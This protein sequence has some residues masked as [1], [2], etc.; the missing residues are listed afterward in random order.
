M[1]LNTYAL[2]QVKYEGKYYKIWFQITSTLQKIIHLFMDQ[3]IELKYGCNISPTN[4]D[5][6]PLKICLHESSLLK[7]GSGFFSFDMTTSL[8][9]E[10]H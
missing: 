4:S 6:L 5:Y 7:K 8:G 3:A 1:G 9:N 10:K 2:L